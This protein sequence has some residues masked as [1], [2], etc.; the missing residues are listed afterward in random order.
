MYLTKK[1]MT[2]WYLKQKL[3]K[4]KTTPKHWNKQEI[5]RIEQ[6]EKLHEEDDDDDEGETIG[7]WDQYD[8]RRKGKGGPT[9]KY[10]LKIRLYVVYNPK[11]EEHKNGRQNV[12]NNVW[13][14]W[15][16]V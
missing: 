13:R 7:F 9:E 10:I 14:G 2:K 4:Y 11:N 5:P 6:K 12:G 8:L 1:N 16:V 3:N 15:A